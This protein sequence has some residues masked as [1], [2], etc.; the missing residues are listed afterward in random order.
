MRRN[1][2]NYCDWHRWNTFVNEAETSVNNC[3]KFTNARNQ[4]GI[5]IGSAIQKRP[6]KGTS[7]LAHLRFPFYRSLVAKIASCWCKQVGLCKP[8]PHS[9]VLV[10]GAV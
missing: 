7:L 4:V 3:F 8:A 5:H 10:K 2:E 9:F 1:L 6:S